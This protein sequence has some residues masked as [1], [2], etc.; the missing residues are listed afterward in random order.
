[1]ETAK[2]DGRFS[3]LLRKLAMTGGAMPMINEDH[4]PSTSCHPSHR[5]ELKK[6]I[7]NH[8]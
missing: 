4:T 2:A 3:G 7:K 1:V 6:Y 5:G 8:K